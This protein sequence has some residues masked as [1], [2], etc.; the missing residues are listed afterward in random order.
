MNIIRQGRTTR[1]VLADSKAIGFGYDANGNTTSITPPEKPDH[2]FSY[3]AV[4]LEE[5]YNPPALGIVTTPSQYEYNLDKQLHKIIRPDGKSIQFDYNNKGKLELVTLPDNKTVEYTYDEAK[6]RLT[7]V[8]A[9][10]GETLSYS[11]DGSLLLNTTWAGA[12]NGSVSRTY[13]NN[14]WITSHMVNGGSTI[15]YQYD[16][17]GLLTGAGNLTIGRN[18]QNGLITSTT[19]G[20]VNDTLGYNTF[21]EVVD[22]R[23]KYNTTDIFSI[24]FNR[25]KLGRITEKTETVDS[26]TRMYNYEY[27]E[28]GRLTRV[29]KDSAII[30]EYTYDSNGNRLSHNTITGAYDAQDRLITYGNNAYTYTANGELFTRTD[31]STSETTAYTYD[32]LG[33]LVSV[34][35]PDDRQIAYVIDGG[36]RRIGKK[37][38]GTLIQGFLYQGGLRPVAELDNNGNIV[39]RFIYANRINVPDYMMKSGV[40]YRIVTDHLG[41]PRLVVNTATGQIV[42]RMDYDE[43][44]NVTNDT[45]PGFQPFGFAGGLYD[46]DTK[47]VR[48]GAR[49]YDAEIGRWTAKDPIL[50]MGG[51]TNL[52]AYVRNDPMNWK[53]PYGLLTDPSSPTGE[54]TETLLEK[55][56]RAKEQYDKNPGD[57]FAG[58]E[59]YYWRSQVIPL[60][61]KLYAEGVTL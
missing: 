50:F 60:M 56:R 24:Q 16:N 17:D 33:N 22:Y 30:S 41:S 43:F 45:N 20:S 39:S 57:A 48:F 38:N 32:V 53:D 6:G 35:L 44:G 15:N 2:T 5:T 9:P 25:D 21:G 42:Q 61:A 11:Y 14:F 1:Q 47:L 49:D 58:A 51:D 59:Y 31:T 55:Y 29:K 18:A 10:G 8:T 3:T 37:D 34:T 26:A 19:L 28:I 36:N 54:T 40:T 13:N 52:Y 4:N 46:N 23:A 12:I 27:D 7:T